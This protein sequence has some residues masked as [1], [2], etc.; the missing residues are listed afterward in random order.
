MATNVAA[1]MTVVG[2]SHKGPLITGE[3]PIF[4]QNNKTQTNQQTVNFTSCNHGLV[5]EGPTTQ[6]TSVVHQAIGPSTPRAHLC[7][8][9]GAP[10]AVPPKL[11]LARGPDAPSSETPP[12]SRVGRPLGRNPASLEGPDAPRAKFHLAR[13]RPG[14]AASAPTPTR[15]LNALRRRERTGQ[16]RIPAMPAL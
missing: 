3:N 7:L 5:S 16:R 14:P 11:R 8:A 9:R 2:D 1:D 4:S 15:A 12:R 6:A 10:G 13:G